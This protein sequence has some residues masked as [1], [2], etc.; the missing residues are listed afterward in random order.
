[1]CFVNHA[2]GS[3]PVAAF[4]AAARR[5]GVSMPFVPCV[6][7]ITD[8]ESL[9]VLE[10]FPGL[11]VDPEVRRSVLDATD[12]REAGITAAVDEAMRMLAIEG[13][14]GVNLSGSATAGPEEESATIMDQV[15]TRIRERWPVSG[16]APPR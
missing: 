14:V 3:G 7:V 2:G 10:R 13:V 5:R 11:V 16:A 15:A 6:A 1:L 9:M 8:R 12:G 4:V